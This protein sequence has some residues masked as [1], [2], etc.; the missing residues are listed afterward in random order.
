MEL[1]SDLCGFGLPMELAFS[2]G[3][4]LLLAERLLL[5]LQRLR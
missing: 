4:F 1:I 3:E 2:L 5:L